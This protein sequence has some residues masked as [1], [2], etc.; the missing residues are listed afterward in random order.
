MVKFWV[1]WKY[2]HICHYWTLIWHLGKHTIDNKELIRIKKWV[3]LWYEIMRWYLIVQFWR[4]IRIKIIY[5][6][7][8]EI[9]ME[10]ANVRFKTID[11]RYV[12]KRSIGNIY[13]IE[14]RNLN[15]NRNPSKMIM[16][17]KVERDY[18]MIYIRGNR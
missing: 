11:Y 12:G 1:C 17:I 6:W 5:D 15:N 7:N 10:N 8:K 14:W 13:V 18:I 16:Y 2:T 9:W 3:I 4:L